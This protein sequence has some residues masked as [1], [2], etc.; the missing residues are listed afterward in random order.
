M[1][2]RDSPE[3]VS[4]MMTSVLR[5]RGRQINR[6]RVQRLMRLMGIRSLCPQP[7]TTTPNKAHPVYPY[8]LRDLPVTRPNQV[9]AADITY[10]PFK[11][12]FWYLVAIMDWHSR[13]VLSWRLANTMTADFCV[14][15]LNEALALYGAPEIFNSDQG[16][17]FTA[18]AFTSVLLEAGVKIS[19]D[20]VGRADV[21]KRQVFGCGQRLLIPMRRIS[22]WTRLR[23]TSR[24]RRRKTEVII[25]EPFSG[26]AR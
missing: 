18:E 7:K 8:L 12:G 20:G 17:Q 10:I 3:N 21:Y 1:C 16:S 4:R 15:A 14:A 22:R 5:R 23:L 24:P 11:K 26:W 9:W 13:K 25:R 6:K 2:I 19:M